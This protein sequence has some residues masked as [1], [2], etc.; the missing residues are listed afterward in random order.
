MYLQ[1]RNRLI[2]TDNEL[3]LPKLKTGVQIGN[4]GLTNKHC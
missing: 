4:L 1:N 2:G 3:W